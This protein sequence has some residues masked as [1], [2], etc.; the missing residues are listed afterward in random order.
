MV[1]LVTTLLQFFHRMCRWKNWK[2]VN[3]W[4]RYGQKFANYFYGPL[5]TSCTHTVH[6]SSRLCDFVKV[7]SAKA[8]SHVNETEMTKFCN[9]NR[10]WL[11]TKDFSSCSDDKQIK[12]KKLY[13]ITVVYG[14][15]WHGEDSK[16]STKS[17]ASF[18]IRHRFQRCAAKYCHVFLIF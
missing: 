13:F 14:D 3:S 4:Q 16:N 17:D 2:S 7:L 11:Y 8:E 18:C 6:I 5:C 15:I 10:S 1:Y 12:S 9:F